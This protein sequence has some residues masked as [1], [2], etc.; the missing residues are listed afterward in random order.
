MAIVA[1]Y[2]STQNLPFNGAV[3]L[4]IKRHKIKQYEPKEK[5]T[6]VKLLYTLGQYSKPLNDLAQSGCENCVLLLEEIR[7]LLIEIRNAIFQRLGRKP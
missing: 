4:L 3:K 1:H 2:Q 6:L 5:V 7:D